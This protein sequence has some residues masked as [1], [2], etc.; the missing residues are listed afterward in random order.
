MMATTVAGKPI[1]QRLQN[2][3]P[4]ELRRLDQWLL[5]NSPELYEVVKDPEYA[6]TDHLPLAEVARTQGKDARTLRAHAETDGFGPVTQ[7]GTQP[8]L[9]KS[10]VSDVMYGRAFKAIYGDDAG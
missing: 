6:L 9:Y 1:S 5:D 8:S 2:L 4:W 7:I 10:Y 3:Q